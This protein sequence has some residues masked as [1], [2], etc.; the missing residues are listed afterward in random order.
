MNWTRLIYGTA[1]IL[2]IAGG[3]AVYWSPRPQVKPIDMIELTEAANE[4]LMPFGYTLSTN[5]I[6]YE[7]P[8]WS[9]DPNTNRWQLGTN[10]YP[11]LVYDGYDVMT[12]QFINVTGIATPAA[13]G[14]NWLFWELWGDSVPTIDNLLNYAG[15]PWEYELITTGR[16][17]N[18]DWWGGTTEVPAF[19]LSVH[20]A[21]VG[22]VI[23][24]SALDNVDATIYATIPNYVDHEAAVEGVF[25]NTT[26]PMLTKSSVWARLSLPSIWTN[27][28]QVTTNVP[29]SW[30][31]TNGLI[32][33]NLVGTNTAWLSTTNITTNL[34]F[35]GGSRITTNMLAERFRALQYLRWTKGQ[36]PTWT[37]IT[38]TTW[39]DTQ[40]PTNSTDHDEA[41][42]NSYLCEYGSYPPDTP[43]GITDYPGWWENP[44]TGPATSPEIDDAETGSTTTNKTGSR[45]YRAIYAVGLYSKWQ[46]AGGKWNG[47]YSGY[48]W[49]D[50]N[51]WGATWSHW[52]YSGLHTCR[53]NVLTKR[54]SSPMAP[55]PYNIGG[56]AVTGDVYFSIQG[57]YYTSTNRIRLCSEDMTRTQAFTWIGAPFPMT[58]DLLPATNFPYS[59]SEYT[60]AWPY[61]ANLYEY[62]SGNYGASWG[63]STNTTIIEK[64]MVFKWSFSRCRP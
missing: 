19:V 59:F 57:N 31:Y 26:I 14:E 9:E 43:G 1:I 23:Q 17:F 16:T 24:K 11:Y 55:V 34:T 63:I 50:G 4:R 61:T 29:Y 6:L 38:E 33:T 7:Q 36:T 41:G 51:Y 28:T 40:T 56:C 32:V 58:N 8:R 12:D 47:M 62:Y 52:Y 53:T 25:T 27:I 64:D 22:P 18:V 37:N 60:F 21:G 45:P 13:P 42:T 20:P 49:P 30:T 54:V 39:T 44:I 35:T 5:F 46:N 2:S 15:P 48:S 3:T 10:L